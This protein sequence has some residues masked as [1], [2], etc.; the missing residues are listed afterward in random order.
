M[1]IDFK[2]DLSSCASSDKDM[3]WGRDRDSRVWG[4]TCFSIE[5]F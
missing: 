4:K 3:F 5:A 2:Y 1:T